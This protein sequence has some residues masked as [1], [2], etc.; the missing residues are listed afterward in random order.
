M[1]T[2]EPHLRAQLRALNISEPSRAAVTLLIE[3]IDPNGY[4]RRPLEEIA[5][6]N[7]DVVNQQELPA[8]L[9][10]LQGFQPVGVG[11]R[12]LCECLLLQVPDI[13]LGAA[14]R[15]LIKDHLMDIQERNVAKIRE[16]TG[17]PLPVIND[18][19]AFLKNLTASPGRDW[20]ASG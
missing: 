4:L 2:L 7:K 10:I 9:A 13:P 20:M 5:D 17:Y 11:A 6:Q 16:R 14:L 1:N 8:A 3:H 18:C 12:D 15:V 19:I